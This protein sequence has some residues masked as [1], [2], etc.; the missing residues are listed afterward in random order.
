M[1]Q[2]I[3]IQKIEQI[4]AL[5][6]ECI[7]ELSIQQTTERNIGS[8]GKIITKD[9]DFGIPIR[10]F[11]K[12]YANGLSGSKK[13]VLLLAWFAKGDEKKEVSLSDLQARWEKMKG[14]SLLGLEFNRFFPAEAHESDWIERV[15]KGFYKLR[16][17][18]RNILL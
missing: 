8:Q 7:N 13:F 18:W 10:P 11:V 16:P 4:K 1:N 12:R 14:S 17:D 3:I 2:K 6:E 9:L 15:G 5:L